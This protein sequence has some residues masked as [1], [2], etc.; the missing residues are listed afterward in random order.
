MIKQE[1]RFLRLTA[2]RERTGLSKTTI[3]D[4]VKKKKF[5]SYVKL[6]DRVTVWVSDEIDG[7]IDARIA[8][9]R[10]MSDCGA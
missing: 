3:Y 6:S 4:L 9:A 1:R 7:W 10:S 5:P 2:V 8:N